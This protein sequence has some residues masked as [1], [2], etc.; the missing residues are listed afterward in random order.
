MRKGHVFEGGAMLFPPTGAYLSSE[1]T[2][3]IGHVSH[4]SEELR[5]VHDEGCKIWE[6]M[7]TEINRFLNPSAER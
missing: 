3:H 6:L 1:A 2:M 4:D 7:M 5:Q